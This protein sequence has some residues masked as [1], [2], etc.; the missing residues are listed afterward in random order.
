MTKTVVQFHAHMGIKWSENFISSGYKFGRWLQYGM[1]GK[2]DWGTQRESGTVSSIFGIVIGIASL[3]KD[4]LYF[5]VY[6][7]TDTKLRKSA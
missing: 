5:S 3:E 2:D 4:W 1:D 6:L 7:K